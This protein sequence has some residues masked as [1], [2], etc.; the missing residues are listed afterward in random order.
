MDMIQNETIALRE[1]LHSTLLTAL[2]PIF[3]ANRERAGVPECGMCGN[4]N[5]VVNKSYK[6]DS[7]ETFTERVCRK[8]ADTH[9]TALKG[10]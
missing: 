10:N 1:E 7:G 2:Q 9:S 3:K 4:G 8:C 6:Y 5:P